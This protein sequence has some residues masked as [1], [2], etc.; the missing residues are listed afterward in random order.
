MIE[1][2]NAEELDSYTADDIDAYFLDKCGGA[3]LD[4]LALLEGG[5]FARLVATARDARRIATATQD[6]K[7]R[8]RASFWVAALEEHGA[9]VGWQVCTPTVETC[10]PAATTT[11]PTRARKHACLLRAHGHRA[12]VRVQGYT[13]AR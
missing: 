5:A 1:F 4:G 7:A 12:A 9:L 3:F 8:A 6:D 11:T 2:V 13:P 10:M